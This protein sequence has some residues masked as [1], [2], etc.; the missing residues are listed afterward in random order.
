MISHV[1]RGGV[2]GLREK[3]IAALN[4]AGV[5]PIVFEST[6]EKGSDTE[7]KR[8]AWHAVAAGYGGSVLFFEDDITVDASALRDFMR[9]PKGNHDVITLCL[10][11]KSLLGNT[12]GNG[13]VPIDQEAWSADRGFH[14][15]MGLWL[16]TELVDWLVARKSD[17]MREDGTPITEPITASE[18]KRGKPCGFDFWLKDN[19]VNPGVMI[20]NPI[21]HLAGHQSTIG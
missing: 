20:P 7:V 16:S 14:G 17:F 13:I 15:S 18:V 19:A 2:G 21:G 6:V 4:A 12:T 3:S 9:L 5:N 11:R 8:I 1:S 10:L